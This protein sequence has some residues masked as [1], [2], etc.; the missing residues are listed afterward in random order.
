MTRSNSFAN[1][2]LHCC[3]VDKN[4]VTKNGGSLINRN[5]RPVVHLSIETTDFVLKH[6]A[7]GS[8]NK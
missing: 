6:D 3:T 1:S 5:N 2:C 4:F 8:L 7:Y